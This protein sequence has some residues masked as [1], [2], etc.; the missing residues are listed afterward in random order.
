MQNRPNLI[1]ML[2]VIVILTACNSAAPDA[3]ATPT[4]IPTPLVPSKPV[5]EVQRGDIVKELEFSGRISPVQEKELFFREGGY[6]KRV[7]IAKGDTVMAGQVIAEL[8]NLS[9]LERQ[10]ALS[11]YQVRLAELDLADAQLDLEL[12]ELN[13]PDPETIQAEA[14]QTVIEAERA[15]KDFQTAYNRTQTTVNQTSIDAAY[16][17]VVLAENELDKAKK[18][19]EPYAGKPATNLTRAHFQ[20]ELSAVQQEYDAAVRNYN[21][22]TGTTSELDQALAQSNLA[23]AQI[24][25]TKAQTELE[26]LQASPYPIGYQQELVVRQNAVER[27]QIMVDQIKLT[28][29]DLD[30]AI[31]DAQIVAP[32][33]GQILYLGL[34]EGRSIEAFERA[35]VLANTESLEVRAELT[36][37]E[38]EGLTPGMPV[39]VELFNA[40]GEPVDGTIRQMP[41]FSS[42]SDDAASEADSFTRVEL[43]APPSEFGFNLNDR[44]RVTVILEQKDDVLWLPPQAVRSFEGRNFVVIQDEDGQRRVDVKLGIK[45]GDRVEILRL[46]GVENLSEDQ[47]VVGP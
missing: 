29:E 47:V 13:L 35:V 19:F 21:A 38:L 34:A 42:T 27:A 7:H 30:D 14:L 15:V 8:E 17:Q 11:Q 9:D 18:A 32:F 33:D 31:T 41:S 4:S 43:D 12:Y 3:N 46:E 20:S 26:R 6:V 37:T 23:A 25:L 39:F 22:L 16:A 1:I 10:K 24:A 5:Y 2:L 28:A 40:P 36:G 45:A 44:V